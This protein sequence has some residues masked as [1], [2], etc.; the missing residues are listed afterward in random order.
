MDPEAGDLCERHR[1][2]RR[3]D[4]G[5]PRDLTLLD[6]DGVHAPVEHA[7]GK[8]CRRVPTD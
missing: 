7:L 6:R 4:D 5:W 3:L 1:S 8:A 2:L